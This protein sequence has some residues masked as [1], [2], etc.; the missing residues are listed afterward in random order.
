VFSRQQRAHAEDEVGP[1]ARS[2]FFVTALVGEI[3]GVGGSQLVGFDRFRLNVNEMKQHGIRVVS[4][5]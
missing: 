5:L 1:N 2:D 3:F 4:S